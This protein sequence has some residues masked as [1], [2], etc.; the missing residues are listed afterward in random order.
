[1]T[2]AFKIPL[3]LSTYFIGASVYSKAMLGKLHRKYHQ[4]IILLYI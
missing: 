4:W 2:I 3:T 1:M